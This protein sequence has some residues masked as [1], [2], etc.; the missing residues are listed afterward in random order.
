MNKKQHIVHVGD[1]T[2]DINL[3]A[4]L[5]AMGV[6]AQTAAGTRNGKTTRVWLL[7][8]ES[9]DGKYK[10]KQLL[11]WWRDDSFE[12]TNFGHPF[13]H[14]KAAMRIRK[15]LV[16]DIKGDKPLEVIANGQ[17]RILIH[18]DA[19][20]HTEDVAFGRIS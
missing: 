9:N 6:N 17:E 15:K 4:A 10:T 5:A 2:G 18:P 1:T 14:L 11:E 16:A 20:K 3:M 19:D 13:A 8:K 7:A 12:H